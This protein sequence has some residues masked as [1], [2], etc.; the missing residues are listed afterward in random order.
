MLITAVVN[1]ALTILLLSQ[2]ASACYRLVFE[3]HSVFRYKGDV[4]QIYSNIALDQCRRICTLYAECEA[5]NMIWSAENRTKGTCEL[6]NVK[7]MLWRHF[8]SD[9]SS[10][11][12]FKHSYMYFDKFDTISCFSCR[13]LYI[14]LYSSC[15]F[16][17]NTN[18][19]DNDK[20]YA[21]FYSLTA[22]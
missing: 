14:P 15:S 2:V 5:F 21:E 7:G 12:F 9:R 8:L 18:I 11:F 17:W 3:E 16:S 1:V 20:N 4:I 10:S 19:I 13:Y 6:F 22:K